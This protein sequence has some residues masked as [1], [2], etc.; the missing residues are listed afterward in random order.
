MRTALGGRGSILIASERR[1]R[2]SRSAWSTALLRA[3]SAAG[4]TL[5]LMRLLDALYRLPY[6]PFA[7]I[8]LAIIGDTNMWT[9][10]I[11]LAIASWFTTA[12]IVRAEVL[13]LKENDYVRAAKAVGARWYQILVRH[14]LPN[15]L[16]IVMVVIFLELP[17]GDTRRGAPVSS[18]ASG[19]ARR[20]PLG[21]RWCM[22][23]ATSIGRARS[24]LS[25]HRLR[26]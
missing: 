23:A 22:R 7:I 24:R 2:S 26:S 8:T 20:T 21:V 15:T 25:S 9:M 11:A 18:S 19:S 17:G 16:G 14:L 10:M 3:S 6:L 5:G 12:R 4:S 13:T 1:L